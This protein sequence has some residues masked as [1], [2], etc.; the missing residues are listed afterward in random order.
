M[1]NHKQHMSLHFKKV[2]I[3]GVGLIG[4]SLAR[5]LKAKNLA[6]RITG[7]GRSRKSLELALS[8]GVIDDMA[9]SAGQAVQD[10]D[11]VVF[12]SPVG[13]FES[14]ARETGPHLKKGAIL[15]DVGSVKGSVVSLI[16]AHVPA[17]VHF[18]PGHPIAGKEKFGVAEAT[19]TLFHG[20]KCI[21]T[22]TKKTDKRA[23][24]S[25]KAL[26]TA[27]GSKVIVMDPDMH[28][29]VFA[30]VSHMPHV[31]AFAMMCA[32]A[33]LNT[34]TE[35]YL[36][37]SGAGFRDFTRIAA[38][39]PEMWKDICLLN[40]DNVI[41]MLDRYM[42]SLSRF[43]EELLAGDEKKLEAHLASASAARRGLG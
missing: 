32:V 33:E 9:D 27:A 24:D 6:G 37:F 17:G 19:E 26:W 31:A 39:S 2:T 36:N 8:L 28:D 7:A 16:E 43:R 25:V 4:G 35:G 30:A 22:P 21:L 41:G 23:L 29:K 13:M 15:T 42:A 18:V 1:E 5:V 14:L 20:A 10:A 38:S 12:A 40:R 3:I 34:G 11:L